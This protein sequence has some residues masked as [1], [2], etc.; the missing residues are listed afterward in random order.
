MVLCRRK[1]TFSV[2]VFKVVSGDE[3]NSVSRRRGII[4]LLLGRNRLILYR[5]LAGVHGSIGFMKK[6]HSACTGALFWVVALFRPWR[7]WEH[8]FYEKGAFCVHGGIVFGSCIVPPRRPPQA[9]TGH[10]RQP[11][12]ATGSRSQ[13][14]AATASHSQPQAATGSPR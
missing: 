4:F 11:Q 7:T 13:P 2:L 10:N 14:Q 8:R 9:T 3:K 1:H 12:V 6:M 5:R